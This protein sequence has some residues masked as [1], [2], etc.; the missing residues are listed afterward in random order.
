[1]V[2]LQEKSLTSATTTVSHDLRAEHVVLLAI[3]LVR[4]SCVLSFEFHCHDRLKIR[5]A[6]KV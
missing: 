4:Q 6:T 1:M 5:I 3:Y 2:T